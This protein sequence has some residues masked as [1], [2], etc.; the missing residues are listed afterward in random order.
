MITTRQGIQNAHQEF[1]SNLELTSFEECNSFNKMAKCLTRSEIFWIRTAWILGN[2]G[3]RDVAA[4]PSKLISRA[5][6][7]LAFCLII[8][9]CQLQKLSAAGWMGITRWPVRTCTDRAG[10]PKGPNIFVQLETC[11]YVWI[12]T[13]HQG[14]DDSFAKCANSIFH[15][16][17]GSY[18]S[19][20]W[21]PWSL[22]VRE[23]NGGEGNQTSVHLLKR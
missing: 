5:M 18:S 9:S 7:N 17:T 10:L 23:R 15:L 4:T 8:S 22:V 2:E 14:V 19:L 12:L 6:A 21:P 20:A 1:S 13:W 11:V 3:E 16:S